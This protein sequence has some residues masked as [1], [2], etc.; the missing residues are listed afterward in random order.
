MNYTQLT[1]ADRALLQ[2]AIDAA[3]RLYV[4]GIQENNRIAHEGGLDKRSPG[5]QAAGGPPSR[6][7]ARLL[8]TLAGTHSVPSGAVPVFILNV[9]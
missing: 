2:H 7:S 8:F 5:L 6:L 9:H 4:P 1:E 3:D